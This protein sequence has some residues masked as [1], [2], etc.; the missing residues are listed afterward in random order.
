MTISPDQLT[1][2]VRLPAPQRYAWFVQRAV[3][4][5]TVW[6]L[7]R[8]GW[9][10]A[11]RDDGTLLF[12]LWPERECAALCAEFEWEGYAPQPF[13]LTE[14][15]DDLLPQLQHDGI[16]LS[17]FR[18]PGSKGTMPT[19]NLLRIDLLDE[20]GQQQRDDEA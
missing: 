16:G 14:L 13:L 15:L 7:F 2:L 8:Q 5:G 1:T 12:A 3:Q 18:T 9:A 4:T 19:P 20:I 17:I 6:G 10:L 11:N